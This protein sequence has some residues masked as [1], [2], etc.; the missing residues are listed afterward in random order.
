MERRDSRY[1][2]EVFD[3]VGNRVVDLSSWRSSLSLKQRR[4]RADQISVQFDFETVSKLA[5]S[6][7]TTVDALFDVNRNE[8]RL[9]RDDTLISAGSLNYLG[10][11]FQPDKATITIEALGWLELFGSRYTGLSTAPSTWYYS[12]VDAGQI[13]WGLINASQSQTNGNFGITQGTIQPS[14]TRDRTD[15]DYTNIRDAIIALSEVQNGFD[16]EFTPEKVFN[17]YYPK[18]GTRREDVT[19]TFPG[20]IRDLGF[21]RDGA[22]MANKIHAIGSG[23]GSQRFQTSVED[24]TAQEAYGLREQVFRYNDISR[25]TT[26]TEHGQEELRLRKTFLDVPTLT[27]SG[28]VSP[29][30]GTY[31][32]GDEVRIDITERTEAFGTLNDWYRIEELGLS[33]DENDAETVNVKLSR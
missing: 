16:F 15:Y 27:L 11:S 12:G 3:R 26:L 6:L 18:I 13:A 23:N 30:F 31:R 20:N 2:I 5:I 17:V 22:I 28:N 33:V 29:E 32:I 19:F 4:N 8:L 14:V 1:G 21:T 7:N 10:A 9:Y 24:T 25:V